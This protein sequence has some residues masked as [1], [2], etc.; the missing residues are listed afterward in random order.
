MNKILIAI[1]AIALLSACDN[2]NS[3]TQTAVGAELEFRKPDQVYRIDRYTTIM[4]WTNSAGEHCTLAGGKAL[5][6]TPKK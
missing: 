5:T 2:P 1:A 6:C 3:D 4:E